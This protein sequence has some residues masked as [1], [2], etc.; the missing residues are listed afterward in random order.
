MIGRIATR[1]IRWMEQ[2]G[3][4]RSISRDGTPYM[5]RYFLLRLGPFALFLHRFIDSDLDDVHC[6][7][8]AWVRLI[9]KGEYLEH[10]HDGRVT[11][12]PRWSFVARGARELHWVELL[13]GG[14]VWT[15]FVH[16]RRTRSWGFMD[17][18]KWTPHDSGRRGKPEGETRG[19]IFPRYPR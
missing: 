12:C 4:H 7:P 15:L 16:G 18:G 1:W 2:R 17:Q 9:I 5:E 3:S 10:H 8:W 6:H 11:Y 19:W 13:D 14:E